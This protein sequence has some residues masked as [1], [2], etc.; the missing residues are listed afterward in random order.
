ME[1]KELNAMNVIEAK[2]SEKASKKKP[3]VA[4]MPWNV[5]TMPVNLYDNALLVTESNAPKV[6]TM[7]K[8]LVFI[9]DLKDARN[10]SAYITKCAEIATI[11]PLCDIESSNVE[12]AKNRL[13]KA[14]E[15]IEKAT[16]SNDYISSLSVKAAEGNACDY[17][18]FML[19]AHEIDKAINPFK[20]WDAEKHTT[21]GK[22]LLDIAAYR[23]GVIDLLEYNGKAISTARRNNDLA[24]INKVVNLAKVDGEVFKAIKVPTNA[25]SWAT[26]NSLLHKLLSAVGKFTE[27]VDKN[28][29]HNASFS[30]KSEAQLT[31]DLLCFMY[32][33]RYSM[34][35][36]AEKSNVQAEVKHSLEL[37]K[38][39]PAP[40]VRK[41]KDE[42]ATA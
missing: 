5:G 10:A 34:I 14:T 19:S 4:A 1:N 18:N 27:G 13:A 31:N 32:I 35:A 24:C 37:E 40:K 6:K 38:H 29:K 41:P 36:E 22:S 25:T 17:F 15:S 26:P 33:N 28:G 23:K 30:A 42:K 9:R 39:N 2:T 7:H 11:R 8:A 20:L 12:N 16:A 3:V 21:S